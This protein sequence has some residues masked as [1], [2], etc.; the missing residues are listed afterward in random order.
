MPLKRDGTCQNRPGGLAQIWQFLTRALSSNGAFYSPCK[1]FTGE[2]QRRNKQKR[3]LKQAAKGAAKSA[4]TSPKQGRNKPRN[5]LQASPKRAANKGE[6]AMQ[7]TEQ[8]RPRT[9]TDVAGQ[10]KIVRQVQAL[11]KRGLAGRAYWI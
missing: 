7:L 5:A 3:S 4:E 11:A 10:D 8:Y 1:R 9:W 6:I 2:K